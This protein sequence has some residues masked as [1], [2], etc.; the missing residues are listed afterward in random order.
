[1]KGFFYQ[2]P[3][4]KFIFVYQIEK[5]DLIEIEGSNIKII[6]VGN[7]TVKYFFCFEFLDCINECFYFS[8]GNFA[9]VSP[10]TRYSK[11]PILFEVENKEEF[12]KGLNEGV[13]F[14]QVNLFDQGILNEEILD[15]INNTLKNIKLN[16][17]PN[18]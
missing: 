4:E 12:L 3:S 13:Y 10:D 9:V 11:G 1:M 14:T 2:I 5:D 8:N 18:D 15:V 16:F 17:K 7:T 6:P